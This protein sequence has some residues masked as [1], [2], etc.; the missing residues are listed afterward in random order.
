MVAAIVSGQQ[1]IGMRR[2]THN[3]VEI[4]YGIEVPCSANPLINR[5]PV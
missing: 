3:A 4:Y 1:L 2:V 5:L